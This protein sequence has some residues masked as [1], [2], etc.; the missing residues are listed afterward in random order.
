MGE[1]VVP[2]E[3]LGV[4]EE[5]VPG[6]NVYVEEGRIRSS[7]LGIV[8]RDAKQHIINVNPIKSPGVVIPVNSVVYGRVVSIPSERVAVVRIGALGKGAVVTRLMNTTTGILPLAHAVGFR[9]SSI[10]E[11]VGVG[12]VVRARVISRAP[13]YTL[14]IR[15]RDL[16]VVYSICPRCGHAMRW[17]SADRLICP[18]CGATSRRKMSMS[19]YWG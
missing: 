14:T 4:I 19:E 10:E 13:P 18:N 3:E 11:I 1:L 8:E 2:G 17:R 15:D 5:Y 16:G 12:D 7:I 9:V 6:S